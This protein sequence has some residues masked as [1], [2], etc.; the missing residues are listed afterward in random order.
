MTSLAWSPDGRFLAGSRSHT[1]A[2]VW[3]GETGKRLWTS[4]G[5]NS[6]G[7]LAW[8]PGGKTLV[9]GGGD[10]LVSVWDAATGHERRVLTGHTAEIQGVSVSP[11]GRTLASAGDEGVVRLWNM[12]T[13]AEL[14]RLV[15]LSGGEWLAF[16]PDGRFDGSPQG[17]TRLYWRAGRQVLSGPAAQSRFLRPGLLASR[18]GSCPAYRGDVLRR[19]PLLPAARSPRAPGAAHAPHGSA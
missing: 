5:E 7:P 19:P 15:G 18:P 6:A 17:R 12:A 4:T 11:D 9:S 10:G 3:D 13:G 2:A 8:T 16:T 14:C 1:W